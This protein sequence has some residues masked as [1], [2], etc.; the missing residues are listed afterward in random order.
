MGKRLHKR[1]GIT[2][3]ALVITIIVLIILAGVSISLVLGENGIITKS[4]QGKKQM[5]IAEYIEKV[6]LSRAEII[7][8]KLGDVTLDN[9]IEQ[10]YKNSIVPKENITKLEDNKSAKMSTKEGYI[11]II[12]QDTIE[13]IGNSY[14]EATVKEARITSNTVDGIATLV[15][16]VGMP[17]EIVQEIELYEEGKGKIE[18]LVIPTG[19]NKIQKEKAIELPFYE[20]TDRVYYIKAIG[21]ATTLESEKVTTEKNTNTIRTANDLKKFATLVNNGE[22]FKGQT[23][24]QLETIDLSEICNST[25]GSWEPIG[26]F[27]GH[28]VDNTNYFDGTYNGN[29]NSINN[30]YINEEDR[31]ITIG[32][33]GLLGYN[34]KIEK[35]TVQGEVTSKEENKAVAGIVGRNEGI[36]E[37]CINNVEVSSTGNNAGGVVG[38]NLGSIKKCV[39]NKNIYG[40]YGSGGI[41]FNNVRAKLATNDSQNDTR[42]PEIIKC[43]N[44][45]NITSD[46]YIT[47]G[48]VCTNS[49][50][51]ENCKNIGTVTSKA[52]VD[53]STGNGSGT[54]GIAGE[55]TANIANCSNKG[56]IKSDWSWAGGIVGHAGENV[57]IEKCYNFNGT[58]EVLSYAAGGIVGRIES[59]TIENSYNIL[60]ENSYIKAGEGNAGGIAGTCMTSLLVKNCYNIGN[61]IQSS[62]YRGVIVGL[63]QNNETS[64]ENCYYEKGTPLEIVCLD[65]HTLKQNTSIEKELSQFEL[66][67]QNEESVVYGLNHYINS[68][69]WG[70]KAG[71]N[72]GYPYLLENKE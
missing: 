10:I 22:K 25:V 9:V 72:A 63:L 53:T 15:I 4:K 51:I 59:G 47:G 2:L 45:G 20:E 52:Q 3:I 43:T 29:G 31:G 65:G 23:I 39:N 69:I 35:L 12:T 33:F 30:L 61:N 1:N 56:T 62:S 70:Q 5:Q 50:K 14:E 19:M 7:T 24:N 16:N 42:N 28:E 58:V 41:A 38:S 18:S 64:I 13:Y 40:K 49:E 27:A 66:D 8:E 67:A 44:E 68:E 34:G 21:N 26:Y 54:G 37:N 6:E 48:I 46:G 60:L 11:F 57:K 32:L 55:T 36:I 71:I 17:S